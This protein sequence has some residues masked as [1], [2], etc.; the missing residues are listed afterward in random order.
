MTTQRDLDEYRRLTE[1]AQA[2]RAAFDALLLDPG[3]ND[4]ELEM[5]R[6]HA[7]DLEGLRKTAARRLAATRTRAAGR[8]PAVESTSDPVAGTG[9]RRDA[10]GTALDLLGAPARTADLAATVAALFGSHPTAAELTLLRREEQRQWDRARRSDAATI[11]PWYI[12][13]ALSADSLAAAPGT[14]ALSTWPVA[15]RLITPVSPRLWAG[16]AAANVARAA[17]THDELRGL[18]GRLARGTPWAATVW[19]GAGL[20]EIA[21]AAL[22]DAAEVAR[23]QVGAIADAE[24]RLASLA[25]RSPNVVLWGVPRP[26]AAVSVG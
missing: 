22:S 5:A 1:R 26:T 9:S 4:Q 13:P 18:L 14:Y 6:A 25:D 21:A 10:I 3:A 2:A 7:D 15:E 20:D 11:R 17:T 8:T 16:R 23:T 24:G 19:S 12:V